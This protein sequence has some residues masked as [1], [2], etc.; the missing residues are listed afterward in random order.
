MFA[1][2]TQLLELS[3]DFKS[4]LTKTDSSCIYMLGASIWIVFVFKTWT[5]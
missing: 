4:K 3:S 1:I 2:P 5:G